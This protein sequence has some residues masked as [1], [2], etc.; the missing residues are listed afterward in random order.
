MLKPS[1]DVSD[2]VN[3]KIIYVLTL[4]QTK[5]ALKRKQNDI[6]LRVFVPFS[7]SQ[8]FKLLFFMLNKN[9][10]QF[11]KYCSEKKGHKNNP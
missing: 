7:V 9:K 8:V 3:N 10:I 5:L 4:V 6:Y 1:E 11:T 2:N